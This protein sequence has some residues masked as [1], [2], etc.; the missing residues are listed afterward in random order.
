MTPKQ[1]RTL[2]EK[3]GLS[4]CGAARLLGVSDRTLRRYV[5]PDGRTMPYATRIKLFKLLARVGVSPSRGAER[6]RK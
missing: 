5:A 3:A 4:Q 1:L 2:L 6:A